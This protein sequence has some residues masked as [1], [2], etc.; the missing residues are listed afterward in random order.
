[1][2][3]SG[4]LC[5]QASDPPG[6]AAALGA[7]MV[8]FFE[9]GFFVIALGLLVVAE[10]LGP[11]ISLIVTVGLLAVSFLSRVV[12][13]S[14]STAK[15]PLEADSR[16]PAAPLAPQSALQEREELELMAFEVEVSRAWR[17]FNLLLLP[18]AAVFLIWMFI[19]T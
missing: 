19:A 2:A 11:R 6:H 8:V 7:S 10:T 15:E 5:P 18:L 3:L 17:H 16:S 9:L 12:Y 4:I 1:M 13:V 14:R